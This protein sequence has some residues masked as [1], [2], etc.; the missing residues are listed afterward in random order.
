MN[1]NIQGRHYDRYIVAE[2]D[3]CYSVVESKVLD[4]IMKFLF[5]MSQFSGCNSSCYDKSST[6]IPRG[7][8]CERIY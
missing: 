8:Q 1:K 5:D 7:D 2:C 3:K 6:R 4:L